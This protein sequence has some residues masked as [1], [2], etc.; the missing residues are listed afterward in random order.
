MTSKYH[1]E[2]GLALIIVLGVVSLFSVLSAM[3]IGSSKVAGISSKVNVD[4]SRAKYAAESATA[5]TQWMVMNYNFNNPSRDTV[6]D[7]PAEEPWWA[8]SSE[9]YLEMV[10]GIIAKVKIFDVNRGWNIKQLADERTK[11]LQNYA[12]EDDE[13]QEKLTEFFAVFNDYVDKDNRNRSHPT[14][15]MENEDYESIGL[16]NFPRNNEIQFREEMYWVKN[17]ECLVPK[18]EDL[19]SSYVLPDDLFRVVAPPGI[20]DPGAKTMSFWSAPMHWLQAQSR[21]R[22]SG[23]DQELIRQCREE[24]YFDENAIK[25]CLGFDL[26]SELKAIR[27]LTFDP[28]S[29]VV[30]TIDV[31]AAYPSGDVTRRL[32]STLNLR[33]IPVVSGRSEIGPIK[34]LN[35]WQKIVY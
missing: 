32:V 33:D 35:Y 8:D 27:N 12:A 31:S 5:F 11:T 17:V 18:L 3:L 4:R 25:E 19:K 22:F 2:R 34:P 6:L 29:A 24:G 15:G 13:L 7:D 1:D 26:Y 23:S 30:Y 16:E 21:N 9:H 10:D 20:S 14:Y 28:K